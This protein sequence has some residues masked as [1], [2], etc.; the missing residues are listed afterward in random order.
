MSITD[1][2]AEDWRLSRYAGH[3]RQHPPSEVLPNPVYI[4][5]S[6]QIAAM[7]TACLAGQTPI[8]WQ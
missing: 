5:V 3:H 2:N 4:H 1:E 8:E 6:D 7:P